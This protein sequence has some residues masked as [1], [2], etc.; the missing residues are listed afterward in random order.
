MVKDYEDEQFIKEPEPG[1]AE[2]EPA[3][4]EGAAALSPVF[5]RDKTFNPELRD[6]LSKINARESAPAIDDDPESLSEEELISRFH[7]LFYHVAHMRARREVD[8]GLDFS[9]L[10]KLSREELANSIRENLDS[11]GIHSYC[12][13][14]FHLR[15]KCFIPVINTINDLDI[16]SL[17]FDVH[18]KLY[19]ALRERPEGMFVTRAD[20]RADETLASRFTFMQGDS[21]AVYCT[22]FH[23]LYAPLLREPA[24]L[25]A[26]EYQDKSLSPVLMIWYRHGAPD[27]DARDLAASIRARLSPALLLYARN[28]I[29]HQCSLSMGTVKHSYFMLEYMQKAFTLLKR[30]ACFQLDILRFDPESYHLCAYLFSMLHARLSGNSM[31]C[32]LDRS[33]IIVTTA[34]DDIQVL[35]KAVQEFISIQPGLVSIRKIEAAEG[36]GRLDLVKEIMFK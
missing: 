6:L 21:W 15:K 19:E 30:A 28:E 9:S 35:Q 33:R 34:A 4:E 11:L 5:L 32:R 22:T 7:L 27:G 1:H 26:R 23:N 8:S 17:Y 20:V 10:S 25:V 24:S 12:I 14:G 18:D 16:Y 2:K 31:I 29:Y 36:E 3:A 13:L